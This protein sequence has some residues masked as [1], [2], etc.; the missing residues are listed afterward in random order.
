LIFDLLSP[1]LYAT[2]PEQSRRIRTPHGGFNHP[3]S[4]PSIVA[5]LFILS[6]VTQDPLF[7]STNNKLRT[8]PK[9]RDPEGKLPRSSSFGTN[10]ELAVPALNQTR[11]YP[12]Q[13][14]P[15]RKKFPNPLFFPVRDGLTIFYNNDLSPFSARHGVAEACPPQARRSRVAY[16]FFNPNAIVRPIIGILYVPMLS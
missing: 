13:K 16:I 8:I 9:H 6:G 7:F 12:I 5:S 14:S 3:R 1:S 2:R 11:T 4:L 10:N 15:N